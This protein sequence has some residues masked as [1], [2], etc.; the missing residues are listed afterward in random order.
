MGSACEGL[1]S[2]AI[3]AGPFCDRIFDRDN[4]SYP[5]HYLLVTGYFPFSASLK[6]TPRISDAGHI[7]EGFLAQV[8]SRDQLSF[9]IGERAGL[10]YRSS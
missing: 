5:Q 4:V 6:Y 3:Y 9:P 1:L 8:R 10:T 2:V 7:Y